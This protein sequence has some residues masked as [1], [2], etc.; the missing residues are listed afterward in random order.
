M[1]PIAAHDGE[2]IKTLAGDL[3]TEPYRTKESSPRTIVSPTLRGAE[4]V[5]LRELH[6][7]GVEFSD[8][9]SDSECLEFHDIFG[10]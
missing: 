6:V 3:W 7:S 10:R 8:R 2:A 5:N 9:E 4:C 1:R